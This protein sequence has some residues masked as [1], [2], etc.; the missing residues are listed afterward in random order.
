[1]FL[2]VGLFKNVHVLSASRQPR[3]YYRFTNRH[4]FEVIQ[5]ASAGWIDNAAANTACPANVAGYCSRC[6][7]P[8]KA[9]TQ[10]I[11]AIFLFSSRIKEGT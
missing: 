11:R 7:A 1:M 6:I 10:Y 8:S 4:W 3:L 2:C 9:K 5:R